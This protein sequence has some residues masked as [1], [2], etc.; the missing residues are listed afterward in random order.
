MK[1][2]CFSD[3]ANEENNREWF[4]GGSDISYYK[5]QYKKD[6]HGYSKN[7]YTFTFTYQFEHSDDQVYFCYSMP[8]TYS[9]LLKD[10]KEYEEKKSDYIHRNTL[11]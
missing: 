7:Y 11:C 10:L 1:V 9:D 3:K 6:C 5:N 2:L 4:R 8:Y